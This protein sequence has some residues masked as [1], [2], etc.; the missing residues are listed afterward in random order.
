MKQQTT[1]R[2]VM[3]RPDHFGFNSETAGTNDWQKVPQDEMAARNNAILE[4]DTMVKLLR[5]KGIDVAVIP[6][7]LDVVTPD[8]VFPNNWFSVHATSNNSSKVVVYPM[9]TPNRRAERQQDNLLAA[10]KKLGVE[11]IEIVDLSHDEDAGNILEG[12]GSL[13]LD[14]KNQIAYALESQRTTKEEFDTWCREMQY[15]GVFFH[16][17]NTVTNNPIYHTNVAMAVGDGFAVICSEA[18]ISE[19][20]REMVTNTL[21]QHGELIEINLSQMGKFAGNIIHL[22]SK[23]GDPKI[24][25]SQSAFD[26][27]TD[28]QKE[29]LKKYGELVPVAIPTIEAVGGGSA[30][31]V[32]AEV[33][34]PRE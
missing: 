12:T 31:C 22:R 32:I 20:E 1:N 9:L 27:F 7:R 10:L 26:A 2:I 29:T 30:R 33:F 8:A 15:E 4:F 34:P 16:A 6:S 23:N 5:E 21:K 11:Q 19:K 17:K 14:R 28:A 3:I 25:M 13:V 24:V 18:I